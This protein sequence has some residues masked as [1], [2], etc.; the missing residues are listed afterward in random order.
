MCTYASFLI[1][2]SLGVLKLCSKRDLD[3]AQLRHLGLG[4]LKL[5][6]EVR[7][8]Y[9]QL[10]LGGIEVV[11]CAVGLIQLRLGLVDLVLQLLSNLLGGGLSIS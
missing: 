8:L 6:E 11:E 2:E 3:L 9:A 1:S 5:T 10:L 4:F 7:V